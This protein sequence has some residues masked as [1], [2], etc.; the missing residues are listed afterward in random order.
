MNLHFVCIQLRSLGESPVRENTAE[1][2]LGQVSDLV[3]DYEL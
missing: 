3:V 2:L 1:R